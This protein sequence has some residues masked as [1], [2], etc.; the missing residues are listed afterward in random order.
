M[1]PH[2][3][4]AVQARVSRARA[5]QAQGQAQVEEEKA[6]LQASFK[7]FAIRFWP[8][9]N[10]GHPLKQDRD[11]EAICEHVQ[12]FY[13][14]ERL[15]W[16]IL[17]H[18][19]PGSAKTMLA[20]ILANAWKWTIN[21]MWRFLSAS[22]HAVYTEH[23]T[24]TRDLILSPEYQAFWPLRLRP[25]QNEKDQFNLV[26]GG[27]RTAVNYSGG[28]EGKGADDLA[29]DDIQTSDD[30]YNQPRQ[31]KQREKFYGTFMGR[32]RDKDT[33]G[34]FGIGQRLWY[35]D[36]YNYIRLANP[37]MWDVLC[38]EGVKTSL[39][40]ATYYK[41]VGASIERVELPMHDTAL[42][43]SGA[44][45]D[46]R[47]VG[48]L[49][50]TRVPQSFYDTLKSQPATLAALYQQN[51]IMATAEGA[52][53]N[54]FDRALHMQ[55]FSQEME[56]P[57]LRSAILKA[58]NSG[59]GVRTGM[60]HGTGANRE[61]VIV[62]MSN[63]WLKRLVAVGVYLNH[64]RTTPYQDAIGVRA[65]L[66]GLG[67][68]TRCVTGSRGDVG[69]VTGMDTVTSINQAMSSARY[70]L[71]NKDGTP[72]PRGGQPILG[73]PIYTPEKGPGSVEHGTEL[74]NQGLGSGAITVDPN[75][76]ALAIGWENW[77]GGDAYK[78]VC[79]GARYPIVPDLQK[80][81]R[82]PGQSGMASA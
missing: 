73:F 68:P 77:I 20:I 35:S 28:F 12:A 80:W 21:D 36:I 66:D 82:G 46:D 34:M 79:D 2:L 33:G 1:P 9:L 48:E 4:R 64:K 5:A 67:I 23:S 16:Y 49:L 78:D 59:W 18:T 17:F 72:H 39:S 44:W 10:P 31:H 54:V 26:S 62:W 57:D 24:K 41:E 50:S 81:L 8:I 3:S 13:G 37:G 71:A 15:I 65:M 61:A 32:M 11:F 55:P 63:E 60:D 52:R 42:T 51:C 22:N 27:W 45:T 76:E 25:G 30:R 14:P 43:R 40:M 38:L 56:A 53:V 69:Q 29:F 6:R 19:Q 47:K 70:P 75:A 7:A 74:I 58:I